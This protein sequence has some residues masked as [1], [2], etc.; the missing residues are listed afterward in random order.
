M[1]KW[2]K[3]SDMA[4]L[5]K[6][7]E[8]NIDAILDGTFLAIDPAS[9]R[10]G[11]AI[12]QAGVYKESGTIELNDREPIN[13]RLRDLAFTLDKDGK[14][15]L[16]AIERIRGQMAHAYLKFSI[17]AIMAGVNTP[18]CIEVP[19]NAWKA[20]A[21]KDYKKSDEGDAEMIGLTLITLAE[22]IRDGK[23]DQ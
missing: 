11:Y 12:F 15:D 21:G 1:I 13:M 17:G 8:V 5:R 4:R 3:G 7:V 6:Q 22:E 2:P 9:I 10:V 16:L 23:E 14:Y 20:V 18:S 19:I